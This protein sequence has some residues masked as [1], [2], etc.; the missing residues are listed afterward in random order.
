MSATYFQLLQ[1]KNKGKTERKGGKEK[2][3]KKGREERRKRDSKQDKI[4]IIVKSKLV[5]LNWE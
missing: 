1:P 4:L 5:V 2:R 3:R